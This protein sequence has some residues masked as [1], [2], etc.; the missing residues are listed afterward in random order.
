MIAVQEVENASALARVFDPV[1]YDFFISNRH[2]AQ[3]TGFAVR[4]S[5]SARRH[6]DLT[7]VSAGGRL[8]HGVDVEISVGGQALRLLSI[9]LKSFCF[10]GSVGSPGTDPCRKLAMQVRALERWIDDRAAEGVP[11]LVLGDFNR[12]FDVPGED[13]WPRIDDGEPARL[14]LFRAT[15]GMW[16]GCNGGRYPRFI[17]HIVHDRLASRWMVPGSFEELVYAGSPLSDHCPIS[18]T[19]DMKQ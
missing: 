3:R 6:P 16:A 10:E 5:I 19:L 9:H 18:V 8:R 13:F 2:H 14:K 12:R 7:A 1:R 11:F 15:A 17:D 4:N